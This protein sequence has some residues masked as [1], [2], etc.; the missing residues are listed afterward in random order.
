MFVDADDWVD[1]NIVL[2]MYDELKKY[3]CDIVVSNMYKVFN[4]RTFIKKQ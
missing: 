1:N 2:A 3:K 4:D